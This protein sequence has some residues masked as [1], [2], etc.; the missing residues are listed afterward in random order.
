MNEQLPAD[1]KREM[2]QI[3]KRKADV[4][5]AALIDPTSRK[6]GRRYIRFQQRQSPSWRRMLRQAKRLEARNQYV[7]MDVP[8]TRRVNG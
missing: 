4:A 5:S 8:K 6:V 3:E 2:D 1:F 7:R